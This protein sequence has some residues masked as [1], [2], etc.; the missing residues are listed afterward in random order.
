MSPAAIAARAAT[1]FIEEA[2]R[3]TRAH[4]PSSTEEDVIVAGVKGIGKALRPGMWIQSDEEVVDIFKAVADDEAA[5]G[6]KQPPAPPYITAT[7]Q[8]ALF[9]RAQWEVPSSTKI[10]AIAHPS[11]VSTDPRDDAEDDGNVR[12]YRQRGDGYELEEWAEKADVGCKVLDLHK[13]G[14]GW[15][16][17]HRRKCD[18]GEE[19]D[20]LEAGA[21]ALPDD[22]DQRR[23]S[24]SGH[25]RSEG[26]HR[27]RSE[28]SPSGLA[29]PNR[30]IRGLDEARIPSPPTALLPKVVPESGRPRPR[31]D[32]T[33]PLARP[34]QL[35]AAAL[36]QSQMAISQL[37]PRFYP[38][39]ERPPDPAVDRA[40][41]SHTDRKD[42]E[43][44]RR[45]D[46]PDER[47]NV[48]RGPGRIP[49]NARNHAAQR[50]V[51]RRP[52]SPAAPVL[53]QAQPKMTLLQRPK[54]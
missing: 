36:E 24:H 8:C 18:T 15:G 41:V 4:A 11:P 27:R 44:L 47:R 38:R 28:T 2:Q 54:G 45:D 31:D 21:E 33:S 51:N 39:L 43:S 52:D 23:E 19:E 40:V 53:E 37:E 34:V 32:F 16:R 9:Y 7:L 22:G 5:N 12:K 14:K 46:A 42:S 30:E 35:T 3:K 20:G 48:P 26:R 49:Y 50:N 29:P 13:R 25:G 17:G 1:R 10:L 6:E